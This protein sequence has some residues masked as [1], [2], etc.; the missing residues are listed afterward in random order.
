MDKILDAKVEDP[1]LHKRQLDMIAIANIICFQ[2]INIE[3]SHCVTA[4]NAN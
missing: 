2:E 1:R 3:L 4:M